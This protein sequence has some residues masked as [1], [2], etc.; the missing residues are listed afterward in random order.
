MQNSFFSRSLL[1]FIAFVSITVSAQFKIPEKPSFQ[2]SVYDYAKVLDESERSQLEEKL[3]RY[4]DSTTTQIVFVSVPTIENED[5]NILGPKWGHAWGVGQEKEDNGVFIL[6]AVKERKIGI[7][8]GYGVEDRLIAATGK[9]IIDYIITP[10]FK[11]GNFYAGLDKGSDAIFLA[12]QGKYKGTRKQDNESFPWPAF[13]IIGFFILI[14]ILRG[15]GGRGNG[16][17]G[18]GFGSTLS[19]IIILSSLGRGGFGGS[20][21]GG[22]FSGGGGGFGGGFGGGG[23]SG[24][25]SSGGW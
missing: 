25:G 1:A 4:S 6:M 21:G 18:G 15:R 24:G 19:D 13:L 11:Q 14:I 20:S 16:G 5:I 12:L 7:Y 22:G 3:I 8:P 23:F 10:E 2:T 17:R 9:Q